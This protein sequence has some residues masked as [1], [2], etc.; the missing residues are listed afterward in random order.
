[1]SP[2]LPEP[3]MIEGEQYFEIKNILYSLKHQRKLQYLVAW[4]DFPPSETEW[5]VL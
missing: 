1:M 4:K 2:L 5:V 3:L